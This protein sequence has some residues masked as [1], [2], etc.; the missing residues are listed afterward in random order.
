M[1]ELKKLN[2]DAIP[3]ALEKTEQYRRLNQPRLAESIC[4][5]ILDI[6]PN[7]QAAI[8]MM[9]LVLTDQFNQRR[10]ALVQAARET[11][12]RLQTEYDRHYFAGIIA[13]RQGKAALDSHFPGSK[14]DAYEWFHEAMNS[15]EKAE[16][17]RP[18][19]NDDPILRWNTCVRQIERNKLEKR[20]ADD[21]HPLL[22]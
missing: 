8:R 18:E 2:N 21:F 9:V 17:V 15:Y 20:P 7:S 16:T 1:P 13:E 10:N 4:Q 11:A 12:G 5:D 6:E 14:H 3:A 22:E 19:H